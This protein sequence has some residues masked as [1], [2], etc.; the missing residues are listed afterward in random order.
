MI[1]AVALG[2]MP[3]AAAQASA[4]SGSRAAQAGE[5]TLENAVPAT[6]FSSR[7]RGRAHAH[8]QMRRYA[9]RRH[10]WGPRPRYYAPRYYARPYHYRPYGVAPFFPFGFGG[11]GFQ[12]SW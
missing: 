3:A 1:V 9:H 8:R 11:Y 6:E 4:A 7:H 10:R 12:P 5:G 2:V